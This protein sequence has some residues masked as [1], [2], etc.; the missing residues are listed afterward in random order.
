MSR[1]RLIA[2]LL[3]TAAGVTATGCHKKNFCRDAESSYKAVEPCDQA[4]CRR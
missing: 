1:I 2:L 4:D 3:A